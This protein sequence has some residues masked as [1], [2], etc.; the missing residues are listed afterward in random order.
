MALPSCVGQLERQFPWE[1]EDSDTPDIVTSSDSS[2]N[3]IVLDFTATWC[4]N[5]PNMASAISELPDSNINVIPISVHY[6]DDMA[7]SASDLLVEEYGISSFPTTIVNFDTNLRTSTSSVEILKSLAEKSLDDTPKGCDLIID[8]TL[9]NGEIQIATTAVLLID[10]NY[11]IGAAL[12]EDGIVA[13]QIGSVDNHIHNNVLR[14]ISEDNYLGIPIGKM[15]AGESD[16]HIFYFT[17]LPEWNIDKMKAVVYI[18]R[19]S[20]SPSV[21]NSQ[22]LKIL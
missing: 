13:P 15:K 2:R 7:C 9:E 10:G 11:S 22:S 6:A 17:P 12:L 5:C 8:A 3:V 1:S 4:V 18:I 21:C 14:A 20:D 16:K 19:K